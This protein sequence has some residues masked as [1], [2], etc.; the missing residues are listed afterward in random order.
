MTAYKIT[1]K[2]MIPNKIYK[3]PIL[4][5]NKI[6]FNSSGQIGNNTANK[7]PTTIKILNNVFFLDGYYI[8]TV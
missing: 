4:I 3:S 7:T 5:Y 8:K 6:D 1:L 2:N